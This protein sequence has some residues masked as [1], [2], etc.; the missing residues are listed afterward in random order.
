[1]MDQYGHCRQSKHVVMIVSTFFTPVADLPRKRGDA[2][3]GI[4]ILEALS[5]WP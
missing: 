4:G 1:M 5:D 3:T 2:D